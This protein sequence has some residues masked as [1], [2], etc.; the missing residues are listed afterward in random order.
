MEENTIVEFNGRDAVIDPLTDLLRK[1]ARQ[2]LQTAI[3]AELVSFLNEFRDQKT[4]DGLAGVVRNGHHPERAVQTG[5][6]PS[7]FPSPWDNGLMAKL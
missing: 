3:E 2:L 4:P 1:G 6:G 7:C 5:I